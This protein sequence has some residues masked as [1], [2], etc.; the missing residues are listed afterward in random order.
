MTIPVG[1]G[2]KTGKDSQ[3]T[4]KGQLP[5]NLSL[6]VIQPGFLYSPVAGEVGPLF[7]QSLDV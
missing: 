3:A 2:F 7:I 6:A 5:Y 1:P 4:E